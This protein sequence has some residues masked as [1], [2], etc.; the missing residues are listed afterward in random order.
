MTQQ[1]AEEA[2]PAVGLASGRGQLVKRLVEETARPLV[3]THFSPRVP[4]RDHRWLH[5]AILDD[6]ASLLALDARLSPSRSGSI[7]APTANP[8]VRNIQ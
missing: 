1:L 7:Q 5:A 2:G 3:A 6:R 4:R 8:G